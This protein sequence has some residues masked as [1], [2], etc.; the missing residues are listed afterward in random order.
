MYNCA[1]RDNPLNLILPAYE[2][3]W[4]V[5]LRLGI[6]VLCLDRERRHLYEVVLFGFAN[7]P[8]L[9]NLDSQAFASGMTVRAIINEALRLYSTRRVYR[10]H[11]SARGESDDTS[12]VAADIEYLHRDAEV[13]GLNA[14]DFNPSRWLDDG[15]VKGKNIQKQR[16]SFMPFGYGPFACPA[17]HGAAHILI[18]VLVAVLVKGLGDRNVGVD[19]GASVASVFGER[20]LSQERDSY[21]D[22]VLVTR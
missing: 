2:M 22:I 3:L 5:V 13:W 1:R 15:H 18:G 19:E 9:E 16:G 21:E 6:E 7:S 4:R 8:T 20:P 12:L 11:S 17:R 10:Q 14:L